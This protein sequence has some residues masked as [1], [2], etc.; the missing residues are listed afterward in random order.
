M[1]EW[2]RNVYYPYYNKLVQAGAVNLSVASHYCVVGY[3]NAK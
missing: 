2:I 1:S 3:I